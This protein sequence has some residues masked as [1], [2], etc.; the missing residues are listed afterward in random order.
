MQTGK[1]SPEKNDNLDSLV[2]AD[3]TIPGYRI[4]AGA[5]VMIAPYFI[6]RQEAFRPDP[7]QFDPDRFAPDAV[8]A[9]HPFAYLLFSLGPRICIGMQFAL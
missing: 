6:H 8:N 2:V 1:P 7:L 4:P 9:R 3:D 5:I